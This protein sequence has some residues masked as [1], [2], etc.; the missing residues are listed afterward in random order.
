MCAPVSVTAGGTIIG[1]SAA[2]SALFSQVL[3]ILTMVGVL[4]FSIKN[5]IRKA[6]A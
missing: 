6:R 3:G 4:F 2:K 5:A 1:V